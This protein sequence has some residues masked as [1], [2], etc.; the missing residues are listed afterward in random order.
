MTADGSVTH[1]LRRLGAGDAAAAQPLWD[2][3]FDRLV[4]LAGRHLRGAP[5][6]AADEE[7][8]ALSAFDSFC[9]GAALG[10][11]PQ[12]HDR[13]NL[14]GLLVLITARKAVNLA[15]HERRQ[16]RGGGRLVNDA[17][18]PGSADS[19]ATD[20]PI[21]QVAGREPTPEFAALVAEECRRLLDRL[22]DADLRQI[23]VWKMEGY[24]NAEIA[25]KID[26]SEPTVERRLNRI[27]KLWQE[28]G[29]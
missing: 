13:D 27:R 10:R 15:V 29:R 14:W 1:W 19:S 17:T 12:L 16:K 28:G 22:P 18:P 5:R 3:Y 21:D 2:R 26:R 8:V 24:T 6:R 4:R 9:Q 25:A 7:D 11:F 23:A 20:G